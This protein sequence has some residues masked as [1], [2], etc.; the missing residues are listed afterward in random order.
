MPAV[1]LGKQWTEESNDVKDQYKK[2]A[3][4]IKDQ[5]L[6]DHPEYQYRPRKPTEKKRRM[7]KRKAA[8][9]AEQAAKENGEKK[10]LVNNASSSFNPEE[11]GLDSHLTHKS[12]VPLGSVMHNAEALS[13]HVVAE[14]QGYP[15]PAPLEMEYTSEANTVLTLGDDTALPLDF[16]L[17]TDAFNTSAVTPQLPTVNTSASLGPVLFDN[18][19]EKGQDEYNFYI[20]AEDPSSFPKVA[21]SFDCESAHAAFD[22]LIGIMPSNDIFGEDHFVMSEAETHRILNACSENIE[23]SEMFSEQEMGSSAMLS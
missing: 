5:H 6:R 12:D 23:Y 16:A 11:L 9:I 1:I 4:E 15:N 22:N 17:S 21:D 2:A 18:P 10:D 13:S 20:N 19:T 3:E 14:L 8:A 7:T